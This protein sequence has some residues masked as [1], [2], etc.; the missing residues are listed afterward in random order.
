MG[1]DPKIQYFKR[2]VSMVWLSVT[3]PIPI[4]S[5]EFDPTARL[6]QFLTRVF[7]NQKVK[8]APPTID[9]GVAFV[10]REKELKLMKQRIV[11]SIGGIQ[12]ISGQLFN[13]EGTGGAGKTTL[14]IEEARM[15]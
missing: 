4:D 8:S 12:L 6:P 11:E 14:T 7:T 10:G 15:G 13:L 1:V 9:H 3:K 2:P 5:T